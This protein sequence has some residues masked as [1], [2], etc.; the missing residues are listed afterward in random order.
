MAEVRADKVIL[1][2]RGISL[3]Q[4]L[5][6]DFLPETLTDRAILKIAPEVIL[7]ADHTKIGRVSSA[8]LAPLSKIHRLVTDKS[9][10]RG[11]LAALRKRNIEVSLA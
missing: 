11:F 4:G 7:A 2:A 5:T 9:A 10:P 1:G 3:E 8:F 6:N